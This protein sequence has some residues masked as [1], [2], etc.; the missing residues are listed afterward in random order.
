[1]EKHSNKWQ[2]SESGVEQLVEIF[3]K[4]NELVVDPFAG[5]GTFLKIAKDLGRNAKGAEIK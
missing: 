5:S 3:T 2:Q 4:P 1:M